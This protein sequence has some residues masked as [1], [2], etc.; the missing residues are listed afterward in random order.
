MQEVKSCDLCLVYDR[1][2]SCLDPNVLLLLPSFSFLLLL[3]PSQHLGVFSC[4]SCNWKLLSRYVSV[5]YF[6]YE[7]LNGSV[8]P[9]LVPELHCL[10]AY[11]G[12]R[13][14]Y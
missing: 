14:F 11:L 13:A 9:R 8:E 2:K 6:T 7:S 12:I 1:E 5:G 10:C 4:Q 3:L